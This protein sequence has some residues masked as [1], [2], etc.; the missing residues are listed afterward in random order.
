NL[1]L[2]FKVTSLILGILVLKLFANGFHEF[3]EGGVLPVNQEVMSVVGL[4]AKSSTGAIII[5]LMLAFLIVM[6]VYDVLR[7]PRPDLTH[8]KPAERR[9]QR[10]EFAKEKYSKLGLGIALMS[11]VLVI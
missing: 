2:F 11:L 3:F 9:K 5:A 7:M 4:L 10:Y 1:S 6:V 8:L